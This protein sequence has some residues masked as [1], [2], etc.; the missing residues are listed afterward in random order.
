MLMTPF[1]LDAAGANPPARGRDPSQALYE[2]AAGLLASAGGLR[3]AAHAPHAAGA[4][5]PTLA[6]LEA[7]L[8]A[9][10]GVVERLRIQTDRAPSERGTASPKT[11]PGGSEIEQRFRHLI[12]ALEDSRIACAYA[13]EAVGPVQ[14]CAR[15]TWR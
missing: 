8:D 1:D 5:G 11:R 6:C 4:L 2:Q 10:V 14:S 9:L 7:S 13:H 3:A 12:D 15:H